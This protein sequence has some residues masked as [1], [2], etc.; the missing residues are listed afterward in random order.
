M[1][2]WVL[3]VAL[4]VVALA[5]LARR[6]ILGE[7]TGMGGWSKP[8]VCGL[9]PASEYVLAS[10]RVVLPEGVLPA[11]GQSTDTLSWRHSCHLE[12]LHESPHLPQSKPMLSVIDMPHEQ[13]PTP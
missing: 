13:L 4:Q 8:E 9:L 12:P 3:L 1:R 10:R 2:T 11:A 7:G 6:F 5:V